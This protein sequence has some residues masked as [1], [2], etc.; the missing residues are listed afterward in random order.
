MRLFFAVLLMFLLFLASTFIGYLHSYQIRPTQVNY[1]ELHQFSALTFNVVGIPGLNFH[2]VFWTFI[3]Y[4]HSYQITVI[5]ML[6]QFL[7]STF[8]GYSH[9]YQIRPTQVN[10]FELGPFSGVIFNVVGIPSLNFHCVFH[11]WSFLFS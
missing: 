2:W 8:I 1:F 5:L 9:S 7:A 10:Y 3:G 4:L 6:L 11:D